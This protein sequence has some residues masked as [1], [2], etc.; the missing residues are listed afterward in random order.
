MTTQLTPRIK[1]YD[2]KDT[3]IM[4]CGCT[5]EVAHPA[6][7]AY[8]SMCRMHES[9]PALLEA[10]EDAVESLRRLPDVEGA[11]RVTC[12]DQAQAAIRATRS[13]P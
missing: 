10:L 11:Y 2:G 6:R 4:L 7:V 12:I 1:G 3:T 8:L 5:I 9:A 13:N